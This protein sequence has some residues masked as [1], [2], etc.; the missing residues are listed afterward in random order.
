MITLSFDNLTSSQLTA[1]ARVIGNL[2]NASFDKHDT[3]EF[4]VFEAVSAE[5]SDAA[6]SQFVSRLTDTFGDD[7]NEPGNERSFS[8]SLEEKYGFEFSEVEEIA[9]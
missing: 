9:A 8:A 2:A 5:F 1:I 4:E 3:E 7:E 6:A